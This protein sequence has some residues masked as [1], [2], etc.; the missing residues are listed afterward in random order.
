M[1]TIR[2]LSVGSRGDLQPYLA[3][4]LELQRRG[5]SVPLIGSVNFEAIATA[6]GMPFVPLPGDYRQLLGSKQG[7]E[8]MQGKPV[9]LVSNQLLEA[10]LT[11]A[12][13]AIAGTDL[14][15]VTP[16]AL[17]GYRLA[18][19][20]G[21]ALMVLSLRSRSSPRATMPFCASLGWCAQP[22]GTLL[23]TWLIPRA[24]LVQPPGLDPSCGLE[25]IGKRGGLLL[26]GIALSRRRNPRFQ[27]ST[28][29]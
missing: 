29:R 8:L 20:E 2:L 7:L 24:A 25:A 12:D 16:L 1:A 23:R 21:C 22:A 26:S 6:Y 27:L 4:L 18:E 5:H 10:M 13:A 15:L 11:T 3:N 17:W 28:S 9:K 14:L 19:A